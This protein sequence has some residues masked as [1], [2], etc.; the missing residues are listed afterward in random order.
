MS[1]LG[2]RLR[3]AREFTVELAPGKT[4]RLRRP[5]EYFMP[6]FRVITLEVAVG[7]CVGWCGITEADLLGEGVGVVDLA[8]FDKDAC[9]EALADRQPWFNKVAEGIRDAL[10]AHL[11]VV[12]ETTKN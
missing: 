2:D 8:P 12:E 6:E 10:S 1:A 11:G 4:M 5:A 3:G 9:S 7:C